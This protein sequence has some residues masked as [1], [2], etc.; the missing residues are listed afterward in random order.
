MKTLTFDKY[1][2]VIREA[3]TFC[4]VDPTHVV[5]MH[6]LGLCEDYHWARIKDSCIQGSYLTI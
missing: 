5:H 6:L 2:R 1:T 3:L 4:K